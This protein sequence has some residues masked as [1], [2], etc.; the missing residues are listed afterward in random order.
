MGEVVRNGNL[1]E[2]SSV[3]LSFP[4]SLLL[5]Y[6][7]KQPFWQLWVYCSHSLNL[8]PNTWAGLA[9]GTLLEDDSFKIFR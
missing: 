8:Q 2:S 1:S 4:T 5:P 7:L 3:S 9:A 6:S